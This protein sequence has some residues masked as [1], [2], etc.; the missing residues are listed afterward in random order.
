MADQVR[1]VVYVYATT[2]LY[3]ASA[4]KIAMVEMDAKYANAPY[5]GFRNGAENTLLEGVYG[6]VSSQPVDLRV[7]ADARDKVLV[8][9]DVVRKDPW[10]PPPPPPPARF[11]NATNWEQHLKTFMVPTGGTF[12]S[13]GP[14]R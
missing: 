5:A 10:P 1:M 7:P 11:S 3:I 13:A 2:T 6:I 8:R 14:A 9:T 4:G 12:D